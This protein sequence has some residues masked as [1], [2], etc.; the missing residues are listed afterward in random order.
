MKTR[1]WVLICFLLM[2]ACAEDPPTNPD[3]GGGGAAILL[4][5]GGTGGAG[6]EAAVSGGGPTTEGGAGGGPTQLC[7]PGV[8][9]CAGLTVETCGPAGLNWEPGTVCPFACTNGS[10]SGVCVP[11][12]SQCNDTE[13]ET[14][15]GQGQWQVSATCPFVCSNGGCSGSCT[16]GDGQCEGLTPQN[17]NSFG[18]WQDEAPC[19]FACSQGNCTGACTPGDNQCNGITVQVCNAQSQWT[20]TQICPFVCSNGACTGACSPGAQQCSG[21]TP[22]TCSAQGQW[23]SGSACPFLCS[24]GSC[25]GV[26]NPGEK[27]CVGTSTQTC[28]AQGQWDNPIACATPMNSTPTCSGNGVCGSICQPGFADCTASPGCDA[29]LSDPDTC[30]SCNHS[31]SSVGGTATCSMGSCG[32]VCD[33]N[34]ADCTAAN[35]CETLIGTTQNCGGCGDTCSAPPHGAAVCAGGSCDFA[36]VGLWD[37]C[38]GLAGTGCEKDV[39]TDTLNCGGCGVS[40]HGGTCSNGV[41]VEGIVKVSDA[42]DLTSM[43][44]GTPYGHPDVYWT[45]AEGEIRKAPAPGG[46]ATLM[47]SGQLSPQAGVTDGVNFIWANTVVPKAVMAVPVQGGPTQALVTGHG[48]L[49]LTHDGT[50]LWWTDQTSYTPCFCSTPTQTNIWFVGLGGGAPAVHNYETPDKA[51]PSWPGIAVD[52]SRVYRL[53]W[54]NTPAFTD[55]FY[56]DKAAPSEAYPLTGNWMG[57]GFNEGKFLLTTPNGTL[58]WTSLNGIYSFTNDTTY[59]VGAAPGGPID[60]LAADDNYVYIAI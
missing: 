34:H 19:P 15:D 10:C 40:C 42:L 12:A 1:C 49:E 46:S 56:H 22:Q 21:K 60:G 53:R 47:A 7:T 8:T 28:N 51:W 41:C 9:Q 35:G 39:S 17:C 44:L 48:P 20:N 11:G 4:G 2:L 45:E 14:C 24:N 57:F 32:I 59:Q 31:C 3:E 13:V 25:T 38:D 43:A 18:T 33:A 50:N 16:P 27:K 23:S 5:G 54:M 26:C 36:C 58:V 30:G 55:V 29:D 6:G 37:D 52:G